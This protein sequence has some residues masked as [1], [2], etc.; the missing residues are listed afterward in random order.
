MSIDRSKPLPIHE[1]PTMIRTVAELQDLYQK[2]LPEPSHGSLKYTVEF[3][4]K[5]IKAL[6]KLIQILGEIQPG[7][8]KILKLMIM[9]FNQSAWHGEYQAEVDC[10]RRYQA[11]ARKMEEERQ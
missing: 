1:F 11:M 9:I 10:L 7:D 5:G 2:H 4:E 6:P 8:A 3:C